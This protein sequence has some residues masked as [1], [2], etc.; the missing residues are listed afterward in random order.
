MMYICLQKNYLKYSTMTLSVIIFY[1]SLISVL[2]SK[3]PT[4]TLFLRATAAIIG[5]IATITV[6]DC[7]LDVHIFWVIIHFSPLF[8]NG[9][10]PQ[11]KIDMYVVVI[12]SIFL[13]FSGSN[14]P[15]INLANISGSNNPYI[16]LANIRNEHTQ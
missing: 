11:P 13:I 1:W 4:P 16:N 10:T 14:N 9:T 7:P 5:T 6:V 8:M 3:V 15:Y 2:Y 12:Y